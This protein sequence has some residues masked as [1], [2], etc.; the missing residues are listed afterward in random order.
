MYYLQVSYHE[1]SL[2]FPNKLFDFNFV[3]LMLLEKL[4][5]MLLELLGLLRTKQLSMLFLNYIKL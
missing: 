1:L 4:K 5:L 2:F 3:I